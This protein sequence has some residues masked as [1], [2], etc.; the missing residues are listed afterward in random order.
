MAGMEPGS[1]MRCLWY[2]FVAL[3][4]GTVFGFYEFGNLFYG[5][6]LGVIVGL[7][8]AVIAKMKIIRPVT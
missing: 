4:A 1:P 3:I 8:V 6:A 2:F 5:I 7:I